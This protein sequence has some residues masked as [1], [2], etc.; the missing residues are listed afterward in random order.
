MKPDNGAVPIIGVTV[1]VCVT[2]IDKLI[3]FVEIMM[4]MSAISVVDVI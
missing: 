4:V 1:V 2:S 3:S